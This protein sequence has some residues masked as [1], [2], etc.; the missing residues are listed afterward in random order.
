MTISWGR[1]NRVRFNSA[2][3]FSTF[4]PPAVAALYSITYKQDP[5]KKPKSHTVLYFGEAS[6]LAREIPSV[7]QFLH[8][9]ADSDITPDDLFVF[10]H[11]M[12]DSTRYERA[13]MLKTLIGDYRPR[14]NGY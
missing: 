7:N 2:G 14:G 12:P 9:I 1:L 13:Q 6:D 4:V 11:P 10:V 3:P 5:G 8:E